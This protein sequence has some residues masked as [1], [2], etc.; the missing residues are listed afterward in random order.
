MCFVPLGWPCWYRDRASPVHTFAGVFVETQGPVRFVDM[1][2]TPRVLGSLRSRPLKDGQNVEV[3]SPTLHAVSAVSRQRQQTV[4][5]PVP[6]DGEGDPMPLSCGFAMYFS[7]IGHSLGISLHRVLLHMCTV[8]MDARNVCVI[9]WGV[10]DGAL[11]GTEGTIYAVRNG[12][13][14]TMNSRA[15]GTEFIFGAPKVSKKYWGGQEWSGKSP[16]RGLLDQAQGRAPNAPAPVGVKATFGTDL[17][18]AAVQEVKT[19]N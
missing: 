18:G 13:S 7:E 16:R 3:W 19:M 2:D 1:N 12:L 6:S 10:G 11:E 9:W 4:P 8:G 14:A 17:V 15:E 5:A